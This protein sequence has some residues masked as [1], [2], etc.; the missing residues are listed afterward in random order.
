MRLSPFKNPTAKCFSCPRFYIFLS[1]S[2]IL[3]LDVELFWSQFKVFFIFTLL[4]F[5]LV[6]TLYSTMANSCSKTNFPFR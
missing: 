3:S 6:P 5:S 2:A 4:I 1:F